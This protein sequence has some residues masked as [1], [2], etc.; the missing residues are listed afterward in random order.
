MKSF[1]RSIVS[2]NVSAPVILIRLMVGSVF[3]SEGIQKFLYA[4]E[5]GAGRFVRI[6]I[7]APEIMGPFV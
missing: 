4:A 1:L 7:P 2:S 3:L 6:G 5:L